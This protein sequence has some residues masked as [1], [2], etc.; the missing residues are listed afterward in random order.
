MIKPY[1][2]N[3]NKIP[4]I[5]SDIVLADINNSLHNNSSLKILSLKKI[6]LVLP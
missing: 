1:K 2:Q 6:K 4:K 3:K 5:N